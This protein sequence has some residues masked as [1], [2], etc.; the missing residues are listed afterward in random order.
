M[1][2]LGNFDYD[3]RP[4]PIGVARP[5]LDAGLYEQ[6][7]DTFPDP[8]EFPAFR[9]DE[10]GRITKFS[11]SARTH[12]RWLTR[13]LKEN[14]PWM[15]LYSYLYSVRFLN[16]LLGHLEERGLRVTR[17]RPGGATYWISMMAPWL[18]RSGLP[19][20]ERLAFSAPRRFG[21]LGTKLEFSALPGNAGGF[22]P[23]TDSP[24][25]IIT[26]VLAFPRI[27][28]W[29]MEY[30]GGTSIVEP[31][32]DRHYYNYYNRSL[33]FDEVRVRRVVAYQPNQAMLF[34]KTFNSWH[35]VMPTSGADHLWR[36]TVTVNVMS[37][38]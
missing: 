34:I 7:A 6:L 20:L 15:S 8:S 27:G 13:F 25:K 22:V 3:Y 24:G 19:G 4:F 1:L 11:L 36:K 23:H 18:A 2:N 5:I 28:E 16:D 21:S 9:K 14:P 32:D 29:Q 30:G 37:G 38:A 17:K 12:R 35:A 31:L 10:R 33:R 26:L